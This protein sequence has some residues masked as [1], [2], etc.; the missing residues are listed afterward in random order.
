MRKLFGL[1]TLV[2]VPVAAGYAAE[3]SLKWA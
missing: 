1:L 2:M 3:N